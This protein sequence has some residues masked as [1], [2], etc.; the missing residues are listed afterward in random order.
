MTGV[1]F[2][3]VICMELS[4]DERIKKEIKRLKKLYKNLS[5]DKLSAVTS[6]IQ[7]AAF[8]SVTLEDLQK[9][10]NENGCISTYQNGENQWGTKKSPE[11]D[12]YNT[13]I[14]N[15]STI[16]KQLTDMLPKEEAKATED[17]LLAFI[18]KAK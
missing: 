15:Y 9:A 18:K 13:M 16:I 3:E 11:A 5:K 14:K 1:V 17:E 2:F 7:N 8:M 10:I 12:V 4:K 6:L